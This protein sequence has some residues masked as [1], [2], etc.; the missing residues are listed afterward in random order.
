MNNSISAPASNFLTRSSRAASQSS[1]LLPSQKHPT[2]EEACIAGKL[3]IC[4]ALR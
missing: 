1:P 4:G 3:A 2:C